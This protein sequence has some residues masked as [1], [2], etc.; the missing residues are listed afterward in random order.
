MSKTTKR[1]PNKEGLQLNLKEYD[2]K[3][4]KFRNS[5]NENLYFEVILFVMSLTILISTNIYIHKKVIIKI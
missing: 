1:T 4:A 5:S 3:L 2:E